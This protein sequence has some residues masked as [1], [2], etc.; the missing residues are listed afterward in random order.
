MRKYIL[1]QSCRFFLPD[2]PCDYHKT[3]GQRCENCKWYKPVKS[4][5]V[6]I[7]LGALGDVLRTTAICE[8]LKSLY[9]DSMLFWITQDDAASVLQG[10]KFVDRIIGKSQALINIM[11]FNFDVL[12]NLDLDQDALILAGIAKA[13]EKKGFWLD[14]DGIIQ[15]SSSSAKQYFLLSHDDRLKKENKKTY[16]SF[17]AE[18]AGL[19]GYGEIVVP[20]SDF[21]RLKAKKFAEKNNLTGS[22]VI[23]AIVGTGTR[24]I[25]KRWPEKN[26]IK[27]FSML[28]NFKIVLFGGEQEKDLLRRIIKKSNKN[29]I[30]AGHSNSV[31]QFF[32]LLDLCDI[33]VCG[34]TFAL[35]AAV[36]LKKKVVALFGPTSPSEIELYGRGEKIISDAPCICCYKRMC[37]KKPGC[38]ELI[39]PEI[40]ASTIKRLSVEK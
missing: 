31:D 20:I 39:T 36:G 16:Q 9:P 1:E 32:G 22:K 35:H 38:M 17:I 28:E 29:V 4:R 8:P 33:V 10:N 14:S 12:I 24:W 11:H 21:S 23:G 6:I 26:F 18:I 34:D 30:N 27:L 13:K 2:R 3:S 5:I 19:D 37:D 15:C 25:T 7:K 40:V